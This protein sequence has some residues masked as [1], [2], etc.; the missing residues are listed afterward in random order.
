MLRIKNCLKHIFLGLINTFFYVMF[1]SLPCLFMHILE[2]WHLKDRDK[3]VNS[4]KN[5]Y[6]DI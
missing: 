3:I 5:V 2:D 6:D 1:Y 4:D